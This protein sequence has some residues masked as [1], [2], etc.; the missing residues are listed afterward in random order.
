MHGPFPPDKCTTCNRSFKQL[1]VLRQ[2]LVTYG[3][4]KPYK[5][6]TCGAGSNAPQGLEVHERTHTGEQPYSCTTCGKR[7]ASSGSYIR[8]IA[9]HL[10]PEF[11]C[12][13]CGRGFR[14]SDTLRQHMRSIHTGE[15][16]YKCQICGHSVSQS[17][18][19]KSYA[20]CTREKDE[21]LDLCNDLF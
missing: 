15:R 5:C 9:I 12:S 14:R 10:E 6:T 8:H 13:E 21:I 17:S 19:F 18:I 2:H 11:I 20:E 3:T 1:C 7:F 16:P 4:D